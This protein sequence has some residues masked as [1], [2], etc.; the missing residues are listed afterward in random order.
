M[1]NAEIVYN[2]YVLSIANK[3][4][5]PLYAIRL[6]EFELHLPRISLESPYGLCF[7]YMLAFSFASL[8]SYPPPVSSFPPPRVVC[9]HDRID[10][11]ASTR[12]RNQTNVFPQR[13]LD[14]DLGLSTA[15]GRRTLIFAECNVRSSCLQ[16]FFSV[17][18]LHFV[19]FY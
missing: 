16:V 19:P 6:T 18:S 3:F 2:S 10:L 13:F 5:F 14:Y 11:L 1:N 12:C 7:F 9:F 8:M 17:S 4:I 15:V